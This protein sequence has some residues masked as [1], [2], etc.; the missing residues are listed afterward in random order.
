LIDTEQVHQEAFCATH[1]TPFC[2]KHTMEDLRLGLKGQFSFRPGTNR[3]HACLYAAACCYSA[4]RPLFRAHKYC[5]TVQFFSWKFSSSVS[6]FLYFTCEHSKGK[7]ELQFILYN[8]FWI[9]HS[10]QPIHARTWKVFKLH[11]IRTCSIQTV[12]GRRRDGEM[13]IGVVSEL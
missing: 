1:H 5:C 13:V 2:K 9:I 8:F 3:W 4:E 6:M 11:C 7:T 12:L 10:L